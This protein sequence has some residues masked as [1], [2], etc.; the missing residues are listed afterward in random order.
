[1]IELSASHEYT[2]DGQRFPGVTEIL[3]ATGLVRY[4]NADPWFLERGTAIHSATAMIDN[5]TLDW[6]SVDSRITGFLDAYMKFKEETFMTY[7]EHIEEPLAH[8][9][10]RFCGCP[11]R[12]N[13]EYLLDIKGV[14]G[15]AIQIESYAEL[16]RA[17]GFNPGRTGYMLHL[18]EDGT[19]KL[20]AHKFDRRLLGVFLSAVSVFHYRKEKGLI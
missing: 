2:V 3:A 9:T 6:G 1:M 4:F 8:P 18:K 5:G 19:Y 13:D 11:D 10:Y 14:Q 16:L 15:Y 20:E 7:W 17:N 12:W